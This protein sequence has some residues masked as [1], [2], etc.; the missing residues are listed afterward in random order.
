MYR[1]EQSQRD[2]KL[3]MGARTKTENRSMLSAKILEEITSGCSLD[4]G[5][6][7][8]HIVLKPDSTL[9][10]LCRD[11]LRQLFI[12][13][14]CVMFN[15]DTSGYWQ[16][17]KNYF[18]EVNYLAII[19]KGTVFLGWIGATEWWDEKRQIV[20]LDTVNIMKYAQK[21]PIVGMAVTYLLFIVTLF[22]SAVYYISFRTQSPLVYRLAEHLATTKGVY[23]SMNANG[24]PIPKSIAAAAQFVAH[25]ISSEKR[26]DREKFIIRGAYSNNLYGE[27]VPRSHSDR[28]NRFFIENLDLERGD[29]ILGVIE[30]SYFT[31]STLKLFGLKNVLIKKLLL[32]A[33]RTKKAMSWQPLRT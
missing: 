28:V 17:R 10:S 7:Q 21:S 1:A 22:K 20:Y 19:T 26:F 5:D 14:T 32:I 18:S 2:E 12:S 8:I 16:G 4:L 13:A 11:E 24:N 25:K 27:K 31:L 15:C 30:V 29:A 3:M 6:F 23:P 9:S 33:G